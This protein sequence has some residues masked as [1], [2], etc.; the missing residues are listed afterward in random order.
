MPD[1]DER[2]YRQAV[3]WIVVIIVGLVLFG[4]ALVA[5]FGRVIDGPFN[6]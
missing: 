2:N 1:K 3:F 6:S 5:V 4:I